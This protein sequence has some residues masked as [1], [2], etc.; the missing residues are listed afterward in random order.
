MKIEKISGTFTGIGSTVTLTK[1]ANQQ[2]VA[3]RLYQNTLEIAIFVVTNHPG[4]EE[5]IANMFNRTFMAVAVADDLPASFIKYIGAI[6]FVQPDH[7]VLEAHVVEVT[8]S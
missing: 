2:Q 3:L 8:P 1:P 7:T 6:G 4:T 5:L